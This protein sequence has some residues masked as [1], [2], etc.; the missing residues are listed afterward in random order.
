MCSR[1]KGRVAA[2]AAVIALVLALPALYAGGQGETEGRGETGAESEAGNDRVVVY[3]AGPGGLA[4]S[5]AEGFEE[6]TGIK[7]DLFQA[8]TGG[9]L[10]RLEA[11]RD[12]PNADVVVLASWPAGLGLYE[13]GLLLEY[14]D[15]E[16]AELL[17]DG[18][19]HNDALFGYSAS[20]LAITYNTEMFDSEPGDDWTSFV[21]SKFEGL[22][23]MPD[24]SQSGSA[25]DFLAGYI[26]N[27][28]DEGWQLFE[29][30]QSNGLDVVGANRPSLNSV[31]SGSNGLVLAGVDYM[32]YN[33]RAGGEPIDLFYPESGTVV[34]PRPAMILESSER[35]EAAQ[36]FIDYMLSDAGQQF[37]V[38]ALILPGRSDIDVHPD[39]VGLDGIPQFE[40]DWDWMMANQNDINARFQEIVR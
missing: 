16:N 26:S 35:Q 1:S 23:S 9:V 32:A 18:W 33:D 2:I 8:T 6:E 5:I 20:A 10:G 40:I 17:H 4:N 27:N 31:I 37:V 11:E 30:L 12:N 39:R 38:D 15:A 36:R 28:P 25:L 24:P 7:V 3:S 19:N 29:D 22:V 21:D 13:E 14:P 34:N